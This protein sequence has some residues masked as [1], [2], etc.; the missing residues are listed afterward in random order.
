MPLS[1]DK[2]YFSVAILLLASCGVLVNITSVCILTGK[3]LNSIFHNLLKVLAC[4]DLVV[5]VG[6]V[7]LYSFPVLW[8]EYKRTLYPRMLPGL[9][10]VVQVW[11]K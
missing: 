9:L 7:L 5:V 4:Y 2:D 6:C 8:P 1:T 11:V 3:R 10:P